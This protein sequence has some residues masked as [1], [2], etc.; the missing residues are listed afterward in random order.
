VAKRATATNG[1]RSKKDQKN[2]ATKRRSSSAKRHE[3]EKK[4]GI[5]GKK[6]KRDLQNKNFTSVSQTLL[7]K[8]ITYNNNNKHGA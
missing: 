6:K 3:K 7:W 1:E 4:E 5:E 2:I 8:V